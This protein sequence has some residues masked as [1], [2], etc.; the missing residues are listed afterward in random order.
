MSIILV[1]PLLKRL[2]VPLSVPTVENAYRVVEIA[3]AMSVVLSSSIRPHRDGRK[4]QGSMKP[5]RGKIRLPRRQI[6]VTH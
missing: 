2:S 4:E 1:D 5:G 6:A 3:K